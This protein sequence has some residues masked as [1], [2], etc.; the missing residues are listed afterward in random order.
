MAESYS[1]RKFEISGVSG[2][3]GA[4]QG[5]RA[6]GDHEQYQIRLALVQPGNAPPRQ[7]LANSVKRYALMQ[8]CLRGRPKM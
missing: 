5:P 2:N 1:L 3:G 4:C 7:T 6:R 8:G